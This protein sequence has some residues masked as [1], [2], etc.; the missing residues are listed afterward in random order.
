[1]VPAA[2]PTVSSWSR[3]S[4]DDPDQLIFGHAPRPV[5]CGFDLVIGGGEVYPE[6]NFTLPAIAI[7]AATWPQIT[8][9]SEQMATLILRRAIA[10][11][12]PGIVLEFEL[13]PAMTE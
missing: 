12:V 4:I 13:L 8:A 7:E 5:R 11:R 1:M 10:M 9:Q 3:L 2:E 6:V